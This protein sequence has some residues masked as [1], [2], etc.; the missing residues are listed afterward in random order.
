MIP[1]TPAMSAEQL[2]ELYAVLGRDVALRAD[3]TG[4]LEAVTNVAVQAV[5]GAHYASI[6]Q[7]GGATYHTVAPT[8]P[9]V[10]LADALQ[11]DAATGPCLDAIDQDTVILSGDLARDAR[12]PRFGPKAAELAGVNSVLAL[13]MV[14]D[15][16]DMI[17]A[18][19]IYSRDLDAFTG[20]S[21]TVANLL[22][23]HGALAVA[24]VISREKSVNLERALA[25]NREIGMAMGVL[26]TIHKLTRDQAFD[27]L[28]IASQGTHRKLFDVARE[29]ADTG[30]LTLPSR[31]SPTRNSKPQRGA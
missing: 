21:I 16:N 19:N 29:V 26:M 17:A 18:L 8:D 11:Y 30:T 13:K 20:D 1:I 23:T 3:A 12:W 25:S 4:A 31:R 15:Q 24:H 7:G 10:S 27:L 6:T 9:V 5:P 28:R 2:V 14:F 22:A